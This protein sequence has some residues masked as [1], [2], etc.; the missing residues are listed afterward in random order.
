M[1][2]THKEKFLS[3]LLIGVGAITIG[4]LGILYASF[5]RA[6][7]DDWYSWGIVASFMINLGLYFLLQAFV[8]K[9]KADMIRKQ[10]H[11]EQ[12]KTFTAE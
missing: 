8:H 6:K 7:T 11:R 12:Q 5:E 4:I 1:S 2:N 3:K 9:V 10:K